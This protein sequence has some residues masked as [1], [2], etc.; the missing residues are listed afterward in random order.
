VFS[1]QPRLRSF[2]FLPF[3]QEV[4][5]LAS[6]GVPALKSRLVVAAVW[7]SDI[8]MDFFFLDTNFFRE[9]TKSPRNRLLRSLI[10]AL[11]DRGVEFGLGSL[12]AVRISPFG[13]LEAL[14]V[15][16]TMPPQ[17]KLDFRG[18][19]PKDVYLELFAHAREFF[20]KQP[21]L[22]RD[23]LERKHQEQ[24]AYLA[25]EARGLFEVCVTGVL[26]RGI[27]V[28]GLF[29]TFLAEDYFLKYPFTREEFGMMGE[30]FAAM[31]FC[32]VPEH[33]PTSRFRLSMLMFNFLRRGIQSQPGFD[34]RGAAFNVKSDRDL[35]DTDIVQELTYGFPFDGTRHRVVA[36]T[37]DQ[38]S[39]VKDRACW[40]RQVGIGLAAKCSASV[41]QPF[42][43]HPGGLIVQSDPTGAVIEMIDLSGQFADLVRACDQARG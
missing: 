23:F 29:A 10:P 37:F 1:Q 25:P 14:G 21:E 43:S 30:F 5:P 22:Q 33:S 39:V 26:K 17:R 38:A 16:P 9:A 20:R 34:R 24:L 40:H 31:F 4:G 2:Q 8:A 35:L 15:V 41:T 7:S 32:D 18:K 27:D 3:A 12:T 19:Q 13:L 42:L 11:R 6:I 36:L 28:T